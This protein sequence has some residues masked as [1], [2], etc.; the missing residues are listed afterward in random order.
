MSSALWAIKETGIIS[1]RSAAFKRMRSQTR[2]TVFYT[3]AHCMENRAE[4]TTVTIYRD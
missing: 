4:Y 1:I 3:R 2:N